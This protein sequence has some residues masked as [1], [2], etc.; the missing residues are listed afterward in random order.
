VVLGVWLLWGRK[1]V[2][3]WAAAVATFGCFAGTSLYLGWEGQTSCGCF[4][5]FSVHPWYAFGI[6]LAALAALL[7]G[8]P[9]LRFLW[10]RSRSDWSRL[11][12]R[13]ACGLAGV[14]AVL[15]LL[16][17][18]AFLRFGSVGAALA[19][20]RGEEVSVRPTLV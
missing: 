13:G 5:N 14:A 7:L 17:G 2:G 8:R 6:D 1:P 16:A 15:G 3:A 18:V 10:E 12:W 20:L 11:L 19:A 4:G 9:D